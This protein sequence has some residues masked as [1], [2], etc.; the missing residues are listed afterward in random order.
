MNQTTQMPCTREEAAGAV[1]A[2]ASTIT[3]PESSACGPGIPDDIDTR[4]RE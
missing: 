1:C 3:D 4:G 2:S